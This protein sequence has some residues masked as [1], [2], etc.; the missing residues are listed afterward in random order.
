MKKT[1]HFN[2]VPQHAQAIKSPQSHPQPN[3][4][5]KGHEPNKPGKGY[6]RDETVIILQPSTPEVTEFEAQIIGTADP[7]VTIIAT[8]NNQQYQTTA[9]SHGNW[10]L[11]NPISGTGLVTIIAV[12]AE[13][14]ASSEISLGKISCTKPNTP[15]VIEFGAQIIGVAD[16]FV[17]IVVTHEG[18]QYQ[19]TADA[20]GN[21]SL[22]NPILRTGSVTI[23]A[24]NA[25]GI[26][27]QQIGL[28]QITPP[29]P[30][31]PVFSQEEGYLV[32][33]ADPHITVVVRHNGIEYSTEADADGQ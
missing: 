11:L 25:E 28:A 15:E 7:F 21:W 26:S 5:G 10:S 27:S 9:D 19:T 6:G 24:I 17:T 2:L 14:I 12:N 18:Q 16:P 4:P 1:S 29:P 22:P 31:I 32:G 8:Y 20:Q 30:S 3:N 13:G 23:V 33:T